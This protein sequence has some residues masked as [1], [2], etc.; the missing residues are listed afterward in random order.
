ML[1]NIYSEILLIKIDEL[2][3]K[4]NNIFDELMLNKNINLNRKTILRKD[5]IKISKKYKEYITNYTK[6]SIS[7]FNKEK[8]RDFI[9][10][11]I[12]I[13]LFILSF[14]IVFINPLVSLLVLMIPM[15]Y[16]IKNI[17]NIPKQMS[18]RKKITNIICKKT[19]EFLILLENCNVRLSLNISIEKNNENDNSYDFINNIDIANEV[20]IKYLNEGILEEIDELTKVIIIKILQSDLKTDSNN[21]IELLNLAKSTIEEQNLVKGES[22]K[23][24]E[25][26]R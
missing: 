18:E 19:D 6:I 8:R 23:K 26:Y 21:L 5:I 9:E 15:I 7:E 2:Y 12:I 10:I 22:L 24:N 13:M 4:L 25:K 17:K 14:T 20:I 16:S 3:K 1:K 11:I